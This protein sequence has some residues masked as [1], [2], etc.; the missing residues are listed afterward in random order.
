VFTD[1]N[2]RFDSNTYS[3]PESE[4]FAWNNDDISWREWQAAGQDISGQHLDD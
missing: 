1:R 4:A 2:L 3:G